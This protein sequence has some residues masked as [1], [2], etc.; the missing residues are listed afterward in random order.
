MPIENCYRCR[1]IISAA[2]CVHRATSNEF[3]RRSETWTQE[4]LCKWSVTHDILSGVT[5]DEFFGLNR[6][7]GTQ[8]TVLP[9]LPSI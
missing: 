3:V 6:Q 8:Q 7:G 4:S 1:V 2:V 9:N 5:E